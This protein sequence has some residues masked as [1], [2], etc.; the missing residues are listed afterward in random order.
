M[1]FNV[2]NAIFFWGHFLLVRQ[3][4]WTTNT[5]L[6]RF[7]LDKMDMIL[8]LD[9]VMFFL[10]LK[11]LSINMKVRVTRQISALNFCGIIFHVL[12]II[13][14]MKIG[15]KRGPTYLVII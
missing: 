4:V 7:V 3:N 9:I 13:K 11:Y 15:V 8:F 5:H 6:D 2:V 10:I 14:E 12:I 1:V